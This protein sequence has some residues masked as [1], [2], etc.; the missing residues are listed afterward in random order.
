[1]ENT[2]LRYFL[3]RMKNKSKNRTKPKIAKC[4]LLASSTSQG[5]LKQ[6]SQ[7]GRI[8]GHE[9]NAGHLKKDYHPCQ[10]K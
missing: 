1:M 4:H 2:G 8:I 7:M 6:G 10:I 3:W 9:F 5:E